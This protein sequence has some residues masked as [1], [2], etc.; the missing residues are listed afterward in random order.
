MTMTTKKWIGAGAGLLVLVVIGLVIA[1]ARGVND[2]NHINVYYFNP[3][4]L[5]LEPEARLQP[6]GE[7]QIWEVIRFLHSGPRRPGNLDTTWPLE[8]APQPEDLISAVVQ[9]DSTLIAF[10]LP[11]F[12]DIAP[13]E[14][15]LFMAAFIHTM[16]GLPS[17]EEVKILVTEDY[18]Y[19]FEMLM[20]MLEEAESDEE[21]DDEVLPYIPL[22]IYDGNHPGVFM[23]PLEL[24]I[25]PH[26]IANRVFNNL[27]FVDVT[28]TGLIEKTFSA[29]E[30][31]QQYEQLVIEMLQI[32]I[33]GQR[34]E[35]VLALIPPET[36]VLNVD[37][38]LGN[39]VINLNSDFVTRFPFPGNTELAN[40]MIYSIVN[41]IAA[42]LL[43]HAIH[44]HFLIEMEPL[45]D[46]HGV[47][48]FHLFFQRDLTL[49]LS[50][51]EAQYEYYDYNEHYGEGEE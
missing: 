28:G 49:M 16:S 12:H 25:S 14:R 2:A 41:T 23:D 48:E 46:F 38:D 32:L 50:Y 45:E 3:V 19:A 43:N 26:R 40:L 36:E 9:E 24:P 18:D 10:F 13:L 6:E 8:L 44:V 17:V 47:E 5:R 42:E 22:I 27:H 21:N 11:V 39:V 51:I 34:Q 31:D 35:G 1:L 30:I 15:S 29:L 37:V 20:L 33:D 4:A 7:A